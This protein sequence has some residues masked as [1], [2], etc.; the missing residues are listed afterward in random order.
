[1]ATFERKRFQLSGQVS[2]LGIPL[3]ISVQIEIESRNQ[4]QVLEILRLEVVLLS[5]SIFQ[6]NQFVPIPIE[7][8]HSHAYQRSLLSNQGINFSLNFYFLLK[9]NRTINLY[10]TS[11]EIIFIITLSVLSSKIGKIFLGCS[12]STTLW[13]L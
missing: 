13:L 9:F 5:A 11:K 4:N 10:K 7:A 6:A 2:I 12:T 3:E 8:V 1:M